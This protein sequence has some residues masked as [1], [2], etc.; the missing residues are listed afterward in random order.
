MTVETKPNKLFSIMTFNTYTQGACTQTLNET[1]F[2][3]YGIKP[4]DIIC[5][6]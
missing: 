3:K 1:H 5:T 2:S 4:P 6:Q